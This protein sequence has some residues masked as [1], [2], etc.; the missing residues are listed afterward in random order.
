MLNPL[1]QEQWYLEAGS[2]G[3]NRVYMKSRGRSPHDG[4]AAASMIP[5]HHVKM[6]QVDAKQEEG[7]HQKPD[8]AGILISDLQPLEL[9]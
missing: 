6:Q 8:H 2:L 1:S 9:R 7:V 3:G 4:N 5:S